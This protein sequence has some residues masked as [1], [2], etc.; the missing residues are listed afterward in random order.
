MIAAGDIACDGCG[1]S[2]T[3]GLIEQLTFVVGTGG[4]DYDVTF[5]GPRIGA[6]ETSIAGTHGVLELTL[7]SASYQWQFIAVDGSRPSK[8]SGSGLCH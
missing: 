7:L 2:A 1:Q 6:L 4:G 3:A 8:A 5:G